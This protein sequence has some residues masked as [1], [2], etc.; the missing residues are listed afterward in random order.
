MVQETGNYE[1]E[2]FIDWLTMNHHA[3]HGNHAARIEKILGWY[4]LTINYPSLLPYLILI[5]INNFTI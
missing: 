3:I 1:C 4:T 5:E 2:R